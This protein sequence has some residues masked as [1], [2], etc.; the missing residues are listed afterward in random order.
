MSI[1]VHKLRQEFPNL[2][3]QVHGKPLVFLDNAA[4]TLKPRCVIDAMNA[5]YITGVS[6]VHRGVH[7]LSEQATAAFEFSRQVVR[8]FIHARKVEEVIF[9]KGAT[10]ALNLIA[11]SYGRAF[12][13]KGDE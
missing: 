11:Q 3:I 7:Y 9:T 2:N 6:N 4:T 5:Y 8:Q 12:L 1:D 13:K 10:E